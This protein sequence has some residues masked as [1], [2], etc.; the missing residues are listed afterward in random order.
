MLTYLTYSSHQKIGSNS[1]YKPWNSPLSLSL[2]LSLS[3]SLP[4]YRPKPS[5]FASIPLGYEKPQRLLSPFCICPC[6]YP[7]TLEIYSLVVPQTCDAISSHC[8]QSYQ[9]SPLRDLPQ[10]STSKSLGQSVSYS[11][12]HSQCQR[13]ALSRHLPIREGTRDSRLE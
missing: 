11:H 5:P 1:I 8:R 6:P 12:I 3:P 9:S 7:S 2:S 10:N 4:T 13:H